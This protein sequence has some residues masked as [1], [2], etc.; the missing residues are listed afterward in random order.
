MA[1]GPHHALTR[2]RSLAV[3]SQNVSE[4]GF[5]FCCLTGNVR[6]H[7]P[8]VERRLQVVEPSS[9][10]SLFAAHGVVLQSEG[11]VKCRQG[12]NEREQRAIGGAHV[13]QAPFGYLQRCWIH[14]G[15][16][17]RNAFFA[18]KRTG[19]GKHRHTAVGPK[20]LKGGRLFTGKRRERHGDAFVGELR[21]GAGVSD[22]EHLQVG[23]WGSWLI[24]HPRDLAQGAVAE[25]WR[26]GHRRQFKPRVVC[27]ALLQAL[28][29]KA[30]S[31][32][33]RDLEAFHGPRSLAWDLRAS[34]VMAAV[35]GRCD[36]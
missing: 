3:P 31:T 36:G 11:V 25:P 22:I 29:H 35:R 15:N 19:V 26:A 34:K 10:Q 18:P 8:G 2:Q 28:S 1:I 23:K 14:F 9:R 5:G 4:F 6:R 21:D 17:Q 27:E 33:D 20:W 32:E 30:A 7:P 13:G 24:E 12:E 16:H